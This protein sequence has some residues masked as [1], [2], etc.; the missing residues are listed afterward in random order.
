MTSITIT[1]PNDGVYSVPSSFTMKLYYA[2]LLALLL[3]APEAVE[4]CLRGAHGS[5]SGNN[6]KVHFTTETTAT[7]KRRL[8]AA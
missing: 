8:R 3:L 6:G 2:Q 1:T 4:G 7:K 5:D